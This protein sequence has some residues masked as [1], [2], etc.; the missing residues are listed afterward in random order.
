MNESETKPMKIKDEKENLKKNNSI[1]IYEDTDNLIKKNINIEQNEDK[2][3]HKFFNEDLIKALN[4]DF[5]SSDEKHDS[6]EFIN[7]NDKNNWSSEFSSKENSLESNNNNVNKNDIKNKIIKES[8]YNINNNDLYNNNKIKNIN[9]EDINKI[10]KILN[11]PLFAPIIINNEKEEIKENEEH[12]CNKGEKVFNNMRNII[13]NSL[14]S[15][16]FDEDFEPIIMAS[17][18]NQ[19]EKTKFPPEVRVGDWICLYCNN[20]NYS[21][22]KNCNVCGL[23]KIYYY[24]FHNTDYINNYDDNDNDKVNANDN[25]KVNANDDNNINFNKCKN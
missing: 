25:D 15:N 6:F 8:D 9:N 18:I 16:K 11:D 17:M 1:L 19:E 20:L 22:R 12:T 14:L 3:L 21:F 2:N 24:E 7:N 4:N 23:R 13:N 5:I 10:Y